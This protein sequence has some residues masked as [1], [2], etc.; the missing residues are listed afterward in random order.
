MAGRVVLLD[1]EAIHRVAIG[2]RLQHAQGQCP[3][4]LLGISLSV[5]SLIGPNLRAVRQ[6]LFVLVDADDLTVGIDGLDLVVIPVAL[7][8]AQCH[9]YL[10]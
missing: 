3:H 4:E 1:V 5:Q 10:Q 7:R 2:I 9:G 6:L 8:L